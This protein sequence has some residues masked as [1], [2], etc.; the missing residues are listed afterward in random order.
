MPVADM[1][2]GVIRSPAIK[3]F[4][5]SH[6]IR[7]LVSGA[8]QLPVHLVSCTFCTNQVHELETQTDRGTDRRTD[9]I[10]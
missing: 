3:R 1:T 4:G 2:F 8:Q 10:T 9:G 6:T 5:R 7:Y